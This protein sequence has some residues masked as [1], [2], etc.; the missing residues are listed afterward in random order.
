MAELN[1][2]PAFNVEHESLIASV[3]RAELG[4]GNV[5]HSIRISRK[6]TSGGKPSQFL[7]TDDMKYLT[8]LGIKVS[9]KILEDINSIRKSAA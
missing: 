7:R 5:L 9:T 2:E 6:S 4:S 3:N 1:W 8:E